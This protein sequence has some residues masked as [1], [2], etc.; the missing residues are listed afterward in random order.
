MLPKPMRGVTKSEDAPLLSES[1]L[2]S[3][4][5]SGDGKKMRGSRELGGGGPDGAQRS[6]RAVEALCTM[7]YRGTHVHICPDP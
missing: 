1:G 6:F 2:N 4:Q 7:S 5:N 3:R